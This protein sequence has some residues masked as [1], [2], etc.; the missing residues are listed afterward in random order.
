MRDNTGN[1][2]AAADTLRGWA[3]NEE[4]KRQV[5]ST[6]AA[7]TAARRI[8]QRYIAGERRHDALA[9]LGAN[10]DR[11]HA[12]SIECI[13]ESVRDRTIAESETAEILQ[14]I[15]Q[16]DD[17]G[18]A[19]TISFDLS[20]VGSLVDPAFGLDNALSLASAADRAGSHLMVSAE[21]SDRADLVLDMYDQ[22]SEAFPSTG[23]T[24]QARLHR[25]TEDLARV[26]GRPGPIRVVKGAFLEAESVAHARESS[27]TTDAYLAMTDILVTAG[28]RVNL[29]THDAIL[30]EALIAQLGDRLQEPHVEFEMLQ[31]LGTRLLDQ[32]RTDGYATREYIVFGPHWWLYVL[33]R[34]AEHPDRVFTALADLG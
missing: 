25:T 24:L 8:A 3:L 30:V 21:G 32:L 26:T 4:L 14:L 19:P 10:A 1:R 12:F 2:E 27:A 22:L 7:A 6:P 23:I 34:I 20:H 9:Y 16:L 18:L 17:L 5:M 29:A 33:N 13:G 15:R 11:G 31:G 28:H